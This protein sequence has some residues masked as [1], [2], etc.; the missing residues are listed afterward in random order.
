MLREQYL[1]AIVVQD[2]AFFDRI[3]PGEIVTRASKDI[4]SVRTGLGERLGYLIWSFSSIVAV[5]LP[6]LFRL[7]GTNLPGLRVRLCS[8]TQA[9]RCP[10]RPYTIYNGHVYR[11]RILGRSCGSDQG[12]N[13]RKDVIIH[14]ADPFF[15]ED[16]AVF[17]HGA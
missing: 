2:Q 7:T 10:L 12:P 17:R 11:T 6:S 13:G 1:S 14:R 8:C 4:D 15:G 5:S 9:R 16:C 3:G